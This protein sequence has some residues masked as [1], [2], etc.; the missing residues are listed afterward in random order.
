M[1]DSPT[2][3]SAFLAL[4]LI[5]PAPTIGT[6]IGFGSRESALAIPIWLAS[7]AWFFGLPVLWHVLVDRQYLS[8]SRPKHG[9]FGVALILGLIMAAAIAAGYWFVGRDVID[10][11]EMRKILAPLHLTTPAVYI[12]AAAYWTVVNSVLEEYVFRWFIFT[13]AERLMPAWLAIVFSA[14]VFVV[15]HTVAMSYYFDWRL[16]ALA[17]TGIFIA[18]VV[19]SALY[20]QYRSVWIPYVTHA[21]ADLTIFAIGWMLLFN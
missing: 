21:C 3:H 1:S 10:P 7:K 18:G 9:G 16:N 8:I 5:V 15:H 17:S 4:L 2:R 14:A 11:A 13:R 20:R 6:L 19:W 12:A